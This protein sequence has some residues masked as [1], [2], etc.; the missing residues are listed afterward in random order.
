MLKTFVCDAT[1]LWNQAST[2]ITSSNII[3][4]AKK[5]IKVFVRTLPV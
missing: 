4:T 2:N 5:E 3:G 1:R